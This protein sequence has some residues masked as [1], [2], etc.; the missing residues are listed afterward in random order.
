MSRSLALPLLLPLLLHGGAQETELGLETR[1]TG[2]GLWVL[3]T[4][5]AP[6]LLSCVHTLIWKSLQL[7]EAQGF[8]ILSRPLIGIFCVSTTVTTSLERGFGEPA[9]APQPQPRGLCVP[10]Q[11]CCLLPGGKELACP[12]A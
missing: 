7:A 6:S 1:S 9:R 8:W 11:A 4:L 2:L 10:W 5:T 12:S 3:S